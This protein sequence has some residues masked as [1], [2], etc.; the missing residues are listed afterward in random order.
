MVKASLRF[1]WR[2]DAGANLAVFK[3][4]D[5]FLAQR[6]LR[7]AVTTRCEEPSQTMQQKR[8]PAV[9]MRVFTWMIF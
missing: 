5:L 1:L 3:T 8:L 9:S 2:E 4:P 6:T 7:N